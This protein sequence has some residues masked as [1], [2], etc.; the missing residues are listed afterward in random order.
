MGNRLSYERDDL[1]KFAK[2]KQASNG[3]LDLLRGIPEIEYNTLMTYTLMAFPEKSN[4][5]KANA[6]NY[7]NRMST[8]LPNRDFRIDAT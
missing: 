4:A 2:G 7:Q 5:W 6:P 3:V 8:D 1:V